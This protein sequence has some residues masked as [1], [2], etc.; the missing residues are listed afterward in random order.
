MRASQ[1]L[2]IIILFASCEAQ[3]ELLTSFNKSLSNEEK[4]T[5]YKIGFLSS[6]SP[7]NQLLPNYEVLDSI[8][9][10][11]SQIDSLNRSLT[12]TSNYIIS[13]QKNCVL[14]ASY[15][16]RSGKHFFGYTA[17]IGKEPCMKFHIM[18]Y[19][20]GIEKTYQLRENNTLLPLLSAY[21]EKKR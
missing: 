15:G 18:K 11:S 12:D 16:I 14:E 4:L 7:K 3:M 2:L 9:L 20:T 8:Q 10:N 19:G 13:D 21:F 1:M 6:S 5:I 17:L